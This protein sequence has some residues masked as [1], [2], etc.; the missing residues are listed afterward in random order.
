MP[1]ANYTT[2]ISVDKTIGEIQSMLGR[3]G[4]SGVLVEYGE[5]REPAAVRF[6]FTTPTGEVLFK[7]PARAENILAVFRREGVPKKYQC[8]EQAQRTAWRLIK[9]WIRAQLSLVQAEL[10]ELAEV[11]LPYMTDPSGRTM[12]EA[13]KQR[14]FALPGPRQDTHQE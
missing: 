13:V 8:I 9:D 12:F 7:L 5:D 3:H 2:T 11:F 10:V 1:I 6:S 14:N 4:A